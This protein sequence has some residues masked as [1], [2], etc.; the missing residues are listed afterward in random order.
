MVVRRDVVYQEIPGVDAERLSL[1]LY[2][3]GDAQPKPARAPIVLYLHGGGWQAGAKELSLRQPLV[4]VPEGFAFASAN[5]RFRPEATV[6]EM[7]QS[8]ADAV[9]WLKRNAEQ[10]GGDPNRMF[11]IGHSAGAHLVSL[12]G[13][14]AT[15]LVN[16]G[17]DPASIRGV[18][19]L[20]TAVYDLPKLLATDATSL[21][22][23]V[24]GEDESL[25]EEVS[26]WHHVQYDAPPAAFLIFYSDGRPQAVT[27][28]IPFGE[29]LRGAGHIADVVEAVGRVPRPTQQHAGH[30]RGH[31]DSADPRVPRPPCGCF[32]V[33][34]GDAGH[35][36][37]S[38]PA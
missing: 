15:F 38:E 5:Y 4:L 17:V 25:W 20:D 33:R 37:G 18:I 7:A 26:P 22:S 28:T 19:S 27:Q 13:T 2:L 21:Y 32:D 6:A 29:R 34:G 35:G 14:N 12:L 30:G 10:F 16:A 11:L 9:G 1:D 3:P 31:A 36:T 8:A 24:F 23:A